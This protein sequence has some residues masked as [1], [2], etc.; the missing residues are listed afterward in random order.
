[1]LVRGLSPRSEPAPATPRA[2]RH[3]GLSTRRRAWPPHRAPARGRAP[4]HLHGM[5]SMKDRPALVQLTRRRFLEAGAVSAVAS[6]LPGCGDPPPARVLPFVE[7]PREPT[8][9]ASRL[10]ATAALRARRAVGLPAGRR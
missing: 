7:R 4:D 2:G 6:V 1:E 9:G 8:P 3:D 10:H 5:S